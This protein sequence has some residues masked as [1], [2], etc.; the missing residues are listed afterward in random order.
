MHIGHAL[1]P[2]LANCLTRHLELERRVVDPHSIFW[3]WKQLFCEVS[4]S[5][6]ELV[7]WMHILQL[8]PKFNETSTLSPY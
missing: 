3:W 1:P 4:E 5:A 2:L 6:L 8:L 7:K